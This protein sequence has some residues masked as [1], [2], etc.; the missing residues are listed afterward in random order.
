[1]NLSDVQSILNSH[2]E[3][4]ARLGLRRVGIFGSTYR[5]EATEASDID[6]LLEFDP[7]KKTYQ[8]FFKST[9]RLES[10]LACPVDAVTPE[11]LSPY[12]GPRIKDSVTYVQISS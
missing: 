10:L 8:N 4:L 12:I 11:G 5:G 6:L 1:M 2:K 7:Q 9:M 3:E